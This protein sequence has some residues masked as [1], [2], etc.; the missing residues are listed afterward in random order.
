MTHVLSLP[1]KV[2]ATS[3]VL[4]ENLSLEQWLAVGEQL[5]IS[6]RSLMWWIGDWLYFGERKYGEMYSQA[7]EATGLSEETCR[8]AWQVAK[9]FEN[10][11]RLP[12]LTWGHHL[13]VAFLPVDQQDELLCRAVREGLSTREL[14]AEVSRIR[15][16][17]AAP[18]SDTTCTVDDLTKLSGKQFGTMY[19]DPPWLYNNQGTRAATGKHYGGMTVDEICELPVSA[20]AAENSHLHLWTTNAFIFE[21]Q[22]VVKAWGYDYKS[23]FVW[24]KPQMGIGNYWRVSHEFLLLGVKGSTPFFDHGQKSWREFNRAEHSQKPERVRQIIEKVSPAPRLE[25]FGRRQAQGWTVWGNQIER[26]IFDKELEA[27]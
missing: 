4:P 15:N 27:A 8:K 18:A 12:N 5:K 24:V 25:L 2:T 17:I 23:C 6:E 10:G 19:V 16:V 26:A 13:E 1:G 22:R 7:F 20:L 21:A 9:R 11:R 14:R 3:L